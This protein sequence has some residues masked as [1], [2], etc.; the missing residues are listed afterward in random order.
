MHKYESINGENKTAWYHGDGM[1]YIYTDDYDYN[2]DY[3]WYANPYRMPG[4]TANT[5]E[6]VV[7][8]IHP[9]IPNANAYAGGVAQGKYAASGFILEYDPNQTR[10]TFVDENGWTIQAKKSYFFFD[11]EII[12]VGSDISDKSGSSVQPT[13]E[14][15]IW[16]EGDVFTVGNESV[17]PIL[18]A[19]T[20][21]S[22]R[23]MHFTNMG[24][25]VILKDYGAA[26]KYVKTYKS[27]DGN[28]Y[29]NSSEA[30]QKRS[31][32]EIVLD[33]GVGNTSS[34]KL[35]SNKYF[36]AY[37]PEAS[38][39]ETA[40]Y[41]ASPDVEILLANENAH[42]VYE[43]SLGIFA[44]NFFDC[45]TVKIGDYTVSAK[46]P[47]A[48]M[49]RNDKI[50]ISDPTCMQKTLELTVNGKT[51]TAN[52]EGTFGKTFSFELI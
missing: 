32:L 19:E 31:F 22:D 48:A 16:R 35:D 14:N 24:G 8:N 17:E 52:T 3:F 27:G 49:I 26:L 33:H 1:I 15:R 23:V 51:F 37:L 18:N 50:F 42:A 45:D 39:E 11:N 5:S 34:G 43:K 46:T 41:S 12:C 6:R 20:T 21:L 7:T 47:C 2:Y 30:T 36:Y 44:I 9:T 25:Y 29:M 40:K 28:G 10:G 13:V 4:V 38:T